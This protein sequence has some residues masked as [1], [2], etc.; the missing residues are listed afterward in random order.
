MHRGG[1][2]DVPNATLDQ[3]VVS[4]TLERLAP[5]DVRDG[6]HIGGGMPEPRP[7]IGSCAEPGRPSRSRCGPRR[8]L[9]SLLNDRVGRALADAR[10]GP[11]FTSEPAKVVERLHLAL[12]H[13][14][15]RSKDKRQT[16]DLRMFAHVFQ[17]LGVH[18]ALELDQD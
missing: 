14:V 2:Q 8:G 18:T 4:N 6:W 17:M 12:E 13:D 7:A 9:L 16:L 3:G 5:G 11:K 10:A 15:E 1:G